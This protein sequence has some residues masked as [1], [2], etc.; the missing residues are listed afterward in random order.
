[1]KVTVNGEARD[2][3]E[4]LSVRGMLEHLA[5]RPERVAIERNLEILSRSKWDSTAVAENDRFEIVHLVGGG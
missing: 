1:M 4:G 5:M 3:P 2:I